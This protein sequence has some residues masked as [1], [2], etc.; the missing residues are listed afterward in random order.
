MRTL[1]ALALVLLACAP[2]DRSD[3]LPERDQRPTTPPRGPESIVLRMPREGGTASAYVYPRLDSLVWSSTQRVPA[4]RRVL[5]FDP[6]GGTLAF[7]DSAGAPGRLDLRFGTVR[8]QRTPKLTALESANGY[9]IFGVGGK[10]EVV[11]LTPVG[12][13][14]RFTPPRPARFVVPQPDGALLVRADQG[15]STVVWRMQP[16]EPRLLDT[17]TLPRARGAGARS[18]VGDRLYL[19]L[20]NE[21]VG[22]RSRGLE[23]VPG[24]NFDAEILALAT[25]PSGDRVFVVT[26]S[27]REVAVVDRYAEEVAQRIALPG[28]VRDLRMDPLGRYLLARPTSGDSAWVVAVA[29]GRLLGSTPTAWRSDLPLALPDGAIA[30]ARGRDVVLV[31][32]T[33]LRS[34][35]TVAGGAADV[36]YQLQWSGFRPRADSLDAPVAFRTPPPVAEPEPDDSAALAADSVAAPVAPVE[37][38]R[39]AA[40]APTGFFVSFAALLDQES[41]RQLA[42]EIEVDGQRARVVVGQRAGVPIHRVLLGPY[43][44]RADADRIGRASGRSYF[45]FEGSP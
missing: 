29:D 9:A 33:T 17:L 27:S 37:A 28:I 7:V 14:W 6:E 13:P 18:G 38:P 32:G 15:D 1:P 19:A 44:S 10:G 40:P 4:V 25:T 24:V 11:R 26:D 20:G 8:M 16:P 5:A 12:E 31:D 34:T 23:R 43:R 21:L 35:R 22:V 45:V 30:L 36:W 39:P 2:S 41:A 42:S 3:A